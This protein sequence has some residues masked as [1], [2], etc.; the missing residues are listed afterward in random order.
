MAL[1]L[2]LRSLVFEGLEGAVGFVADVNDKSK[3]ALN[4]ASSSPRVVRAHGAGPWSRL[5]ENGPPASPE[6]SLPRS[7]KSPFEAPQNTRPLTSVCFIKLF[8]HSRP[9]P[10][11]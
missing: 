2:G 9:P 3:R 11:R 4:F 6:S 10:W 1:P 7:A 8:A 5:R